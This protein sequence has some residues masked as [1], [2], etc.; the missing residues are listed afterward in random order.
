[1]LDQGT[2]TTSDDLFSGK[3]MNTQEIEVK[4][5]S[6][7]TVEALISAGYIAI[8]I[9]CYIASTADER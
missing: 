5:A 4:L 9:A 6:G 8:W 3:T 1:M 7:S 2:R